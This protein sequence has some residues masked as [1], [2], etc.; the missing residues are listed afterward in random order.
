MELRVNGESREVA[1]N[2]SLQELVR[3]LQLK[4]EQIAVELN[5]SVVRRAGWASTVLKEG[6]NVEI[7]HFVGGGTA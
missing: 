2:L 5:H 4:P 3:Y 1:D 7:V 6:D